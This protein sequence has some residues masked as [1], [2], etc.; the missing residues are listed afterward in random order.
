MPTLGIA[1]RGGH[2][3]PTPADPPDGPVGAAIAL[4]PTLDPTPAPS[5]PI[6]TPPPVAPEGSAPEA[7]EVAPLASLEGSPLAARAYLVTR[8]ITDAIGATSA[9]IA[10]AGDQASHLND[11][12]AALRSVEAAMRAENPKEDHRHD[13]ARLEVATPE[14]ERV[15][16][17][18]LLDRVGLGGSF[19]NGTATLAQSRSVGE[20]LEAAASSANEGNSFRMIRLQ[21][22]MHQRNLFLQLATQMQASQEQIERRIAENIR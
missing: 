6:R 13:L 22:L 2:F 11:Q 8:P 4:D 21:E 16:A 17:Q 5:P 9:E 3:V 1:G 15:T 19:P 10:A 12:L 14:G 18:T 7:A 20:S